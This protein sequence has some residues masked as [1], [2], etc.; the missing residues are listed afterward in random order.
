MPVADPNRPLDAFVAGVI[1]MESRYSDTYNAVSDH[2]KN[3]RRLQ[4]LKGLAA[5]FAFRLGS[6]WELFQHRWHIVAVTASPEKFIDAQQGSLDGGIRKANVDHFVK[7]LHGGP[8]ILPARPKQSEVEAL[9]DPR[10]FNVTFDSCETWMTEAARDLDA[11]YADKVRGIVATSP[12]SCVLDLLKA[13]RNALAHGS[14]GSLSRLND[15]VRERP[16]GEK[17]GLTGSVNDGLKRDAN[18]IRDVAVYIHGHPPGSSKQRVQKLAQRVR[19][20][21]EQ[22]RV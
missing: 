6:E 17:V 5:D 20:I 22:L 4:L 7:L 14:G 8:L 16:A 18:K 15:M 13:V 1:E 12:D 9:I 11:T 19:E 21:A 2:V 10:G 3:P